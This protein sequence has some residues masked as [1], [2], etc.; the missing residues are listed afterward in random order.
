MSSLAV[1]FILAVFQSLLANGG[2]YFLK[3]CAP[4]AT[5]ARAKALLAEPLFWTGVG[6]YGLSFLLLIVL[7]GRE[8]LTFLVPFTMSV[9]F[10]I[11]GLIGTLLLG[12]RLTPLLLTGMA[13]IAVGVALLAFGRE[14]VAP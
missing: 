1:S 7:V 13:V 10:V 3:R 4:E 8:R 12:E 9:H 11:S 14:Q 2:M 6:L 5:L